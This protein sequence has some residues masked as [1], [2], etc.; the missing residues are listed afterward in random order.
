MLQKDASI[1]ALH[2]VYNYG[3]EE[4]SVDRK[5]QYLKETYSIQVIEDKC[6]CLPC[7]REPQH[8]FSDLILFSTGYGKYVDVGGGFGYLNEMWK[9]HFRWNP[10]PFSKQALQEM[11]QSIHISREKAS[12]YPMQSARLDWLENRRLEDEEAYMRTVLQATEQMKAHK[13][14][15]NAI[16]SEWIPKE[17]Q[18]P[19]G[20]HTWR[21]QIRTDQSERICAEIFREG[22]FASRH[23][24]S[25][26]NGVFS[27]KD[28]PKASEEHNQIVNLFNDCH[29]T[30][31]MATR[32]AKIIARVVCGGKI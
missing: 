22:L 14:K 7:L 19:H 13:E 26:G 8:V 27:A 31:E 18:L 12:L 4:E 29:Y 24:Q 21:F 2:Y 30:E 10:I 9:E 15:L 20:F 6:L 28:F 32:T 16:Y 11:K 23:Y 17:V 25:L 3:Y 1:Q 5:L